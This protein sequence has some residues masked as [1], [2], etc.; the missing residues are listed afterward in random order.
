MDFWMADGSGTALL[1]DSIKH[2]SQSLRMNT[3]LHRCHLPL[4]PFPLPLP[5]VSLPLLDI[6]SAPS[7]VVITHFFVFHVVVSGLVVIRIMI[8]GNCNFVPM[9]E[10]CAD[11]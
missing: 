10:I 8:K 1:M 2:L 9:C 6:P 11:R 7:L 4:S 5:H 3:A